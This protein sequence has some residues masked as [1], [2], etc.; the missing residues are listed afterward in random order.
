M[1]YFENIVVQYLR[2]DRSL[3]LNTQC[4]IQLNKG[5]NPD[6]TGA[7]WYCDILTADFQHKVVFLCEVSFSN[8]LTG[9]FKRLEEWNANWQLLC[10]AISRDSNL[11]LDWPVRPWLFV[12]E[13]LI[14][15]VVKKLQKMNSEY[16]DCCFL[17]TPRI[18]PLEMVLP[19]K[20]R[21]WNRNGEATKPNCIPESMKN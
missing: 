21:S 4:C 7:H 9:L 1:D 14:P 12:P 18:T 13:E 16:H 6:V 20:Y 2:A 8:S 11:P 19:W 17:P 5:D 15:K 10:H 3:F